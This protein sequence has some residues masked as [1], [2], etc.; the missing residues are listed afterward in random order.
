MQV[1]IA[2]G[3][4]FHLQIKVLSPVLSGALSKGSN[5]IIPPLEKR[6][7]TRGQLKAEE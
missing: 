6:T 7:T 2:N 4:G 5:H 1:G 3:P